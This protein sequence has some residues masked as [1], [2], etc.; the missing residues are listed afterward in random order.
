MNKVWSPG[1][2]SDYE[3][4]HCVKP[5]G[6]NIVTWF[7]IMTSGYIEKTVKTY[8]DDPSL[9]VQG[10]CH[11]GA[12]LWDETCEAACDEGPHLVEHWIYIE[13][14]TYTWRKH[15]GRDLN[16]DKYCPAHPD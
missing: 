14:V 1:D 16:L 7:G 4:D 8:K 9:R 6:S 12:P 11:C 5:E 15:E 10:V 13:L 2:L 3:L